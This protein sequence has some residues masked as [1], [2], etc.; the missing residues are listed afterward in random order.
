MVAVVL[1]LIFIVVFQGSLESM[2]RYG[3][4]F[5]FTSNWNPVDDEYGAGAAIYGFWPLP[6][7]SRV[8]SSSLLFRY[9]SRVSLPVSLSKQ[10]AVNES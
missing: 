7:T 6:R 1:F 2:G 10:A 3:W 8:R 5:L 4:Q 9:G